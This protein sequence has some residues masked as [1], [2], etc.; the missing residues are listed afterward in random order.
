MN[1]KKVLAAVLAVMLAISAMAITAF[2]DEYEIVLSSDKAAVEASASSTVVFT[3]PVAN[4]YGYVTANDVLKLSLPATTGTTDNEVAAKYF[5]TV[6]GVDYA[7]GLNDDGVYEITFGTLAHGWNAIDKNTCLPQ[8][9]AVNNYTTLTVTG[10]FAIERTGANSWQETYRV[11]ANDFKYFTAASQNDY[12]NGKF[13]TTNFWGADGIEY[14]YDVNATWNDTSKS[15]CWDWN[16]TD[17]ADV[18]TN[19]SEYDKAALTELKWDATLAN[20]AAVL[21]AETAKVVV[22]YDKEFVGNYYFGLKATYANGQSYELG[23]NFANWNNSK[24]NYASYIEITKPTNVVEFEIDT[25]VLY[26][27]LY[28]VFNET[29]SVEVIDSAHESAITTIKALRD[30]TKNGTFGSYSWD[31][32]NIYFCGTAINAYWNQLTKATG[33][34]G[35]PVPTSVKIVLGTADNADDV[36]IETPVESDTEEVDEDNTNDVTVDDETEDTNP[37]TGV[38]LA[39][40]P[41]MVAAA[42]V[43]ASK[44]R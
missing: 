26:S 37:S 8:S 11:N 43:V 28:G 41:M 33:E 3:I 22:T 2:A 16:P 42:A 38:A 23:G 1:M 21:G 36:E 15:Y 40:V 24:L 39:I 31:K 10:V 35:Y 7:L 14:N 6:N 25:E 32:D 27:T 18:A 29:M 44:R 4:Q 12:K 9:T 20:K 19:W 30:T 17:G 13:A 5:V 34:G